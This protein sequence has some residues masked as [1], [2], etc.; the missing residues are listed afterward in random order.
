MGGRCGSLGDIWLAEW[1]RS[2]D[3]P[4]QSTIKEGLSS[5]VEVV[6]EVPKW[7]FV[8]RSQNGIIDFVSPLPCLFNYGSVPIIP[9]PDGDPLD[10]IIL[11]KRLPLG[12]QGI[13][14]VKGIIKFTDAGLVDNKLICTQRKPGMLCVQFSI[15]AYRHVIIP[16]PYIAYVNN[17]VFT[18]ADCVCAEFYGF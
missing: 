16:T 4:L 3:F 13:V 2:V 5:L 1:L 18:N 11:G 17:V 15:I 10:A 6:V 14:R 8:K 9:A 12:H 7:S